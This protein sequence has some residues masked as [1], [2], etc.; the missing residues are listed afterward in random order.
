MMQVDQHW[1]DLARCRL[2]LETARLQCTEL[3][4]QLM[5][6]SRDAE[7][8]AARCQR[9]HEEVRLQSTLFEIEIG[10]QYLHSPLA[11]I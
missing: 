11:C 1:Q 2:E 7:F 8:D 4:S 5:S 6:V 9:L 3:E 10:R